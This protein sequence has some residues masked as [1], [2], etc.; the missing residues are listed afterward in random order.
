MQFIL[1]QLFELLGYIYGLLFVSAAVEFE[2]FANFFIWQSMAELKWF[3]ELKKF[4]FD[5][6]WNFIKDLSIVI[7]LKIIFYWSDKRKLQGGYWK[8]IERNQSNKQLSVIVNSICWFF[9]VLRLRSN[10][11]LRNLFLRDKTSRTKF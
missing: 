3:I 6:F 10:I 5:V 2:V 9:L 1:I 8:Q 7:C 4:Q 11:R